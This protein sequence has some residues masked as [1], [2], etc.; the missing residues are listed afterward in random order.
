MENTQVCLQPHLLQ[1]NLLF[2]LSSHKQGQPEAPQ[3]APITQGSQQVH[4]SS[5]SSAIP[6]EE[7]PP[8]KRFLSQTLSLLPFQGG[9]GW[10]VLG[11]LPLNPAHFGRQDAERG[12]FS[13]PSIPEL[14]SLH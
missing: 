6:A 14:S 12:S 2:P 7:V 10:M 11:V 8:Q 5:A 1:E 4:P 13:S 9:R 3:S